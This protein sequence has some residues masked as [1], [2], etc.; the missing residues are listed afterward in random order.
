MT[1]PVSL[2]ER[3]YSIAIEAGALQTLAGLPDAAFPGE[4]ALISN[5]TLGPIITNAL[6]RRLEERGQRV[7]RFDMGDGE[8]FKT[9]ETASLA[10]DALAEAGFS[11]KG[12]VWAVG[13]GVTGDLAGFVAAT[14]MRG[15]S[16]VQVPT[17][18][19]AMVDSSVGGKTG[20]NHP[21]AKNLLGAFWQPVGVLIDPACLGSLS[22]RELGAGLA[23]VI[24][25]GVIA[26]AEFFVWLE[27]NLDAILAGDGEATAYAI[28]RSCEIKAEV[29][30]EDERESDAVGRRATLNYGH[31]FGHSLEAL[32][33][34][35][36]RG[37]FLHGEAIA[38]GM[39][40]EARLGVE[41]GTI[42]RVEGEDLL[43]R[44]TKLFGRAGLPTHTPNLDFGAAWRAMTL[45]KKNR[46]AGVNFIVPKT[47]G[48]VVRVQASAETVRVAMSTL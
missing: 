46:G 44:Q 16:F 45:D 35:D 5:A 21:R 39:T 6:V 14:W 30:G 25:Y 20:V 31:T 24:K 32:K 13:G 29:V 40:V 3:S 38:V 47:L 17:T 2:G 33:T 18:L 1:V 34:G 11:R 42:G 15:V 27:D 43:K 8:K 23:E 19:L 7:V 22:R 9:L 28:R 26:D 10:F 12:A 36:E 4:V 48:E 37:S 41:L